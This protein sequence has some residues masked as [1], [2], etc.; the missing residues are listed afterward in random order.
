MHLTTEIKERKDKKEMHS[1]PLKIAKVIYG[2]KELIK[3]MESVIKSYQMT[4]GQ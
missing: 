3:C 2:S 4:E 1:E